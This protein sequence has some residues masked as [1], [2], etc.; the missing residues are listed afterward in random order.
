MDEAFHALSE[1]SILSGL[2][3]DLAVHFMQSL[4]KL[5]V[6]K[7][8]NEDMWTYIR[9]CHMCPDAVKATLPYEN[10]VANA[11]DWIFKDTKTAKL[12]NYKQVWA[13]TVYNVLNQRNDS[14][15]MGHQAEQTN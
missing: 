3:Y 11:M 14:A 12:Q 13:A 2:Q 5:K 9:C 8:S 10:V 7:W 6:D 15:N 4:S 1:E